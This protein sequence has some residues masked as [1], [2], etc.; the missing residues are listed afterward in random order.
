MPIDVMEVARLEP[1][2]VLEMRSVKSPFP[3]AVTYAFED[4]AGGTAISVRVRGEPGAWYR[5]A[6]AL[7][8]R[9]VQRSIDADVR[10]LKEILERTRSSEET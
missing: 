3:M 10:R 7:M 6:G 5:I 2:S 8:S 4:A 9:T 1:G